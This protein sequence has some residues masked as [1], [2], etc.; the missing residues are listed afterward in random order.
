MPPA[1]PAPAVS[2]GTLH[3]N[4]DG[5][6]TGTAAALRVT[7]PDGQ[8][9]TVTGTATLAQRPPGTYVV[10]ATDVAA[11]DAVYH[12]SVEGSPARVDAGQTATVQVHYAPVALGITTF[13]ADHL[14]LPSTGGRVLLSWTAP[15]A[16]DFTLE[17]TP[18]GGVSGLPAPHTTERTAT[19][20]VPANPG[21][22]SLA[23]VFRL[24]AH[25]AQDGAAV[26][27]DLTVTVAGRA[28]GT[29]D[30]GV[31]GLPPGAPAAVTV[32]DPAGE[33]RRV[34]GPTALGDLPPGTYAVTAGSVTAGGLNYDGAVTGSPAQVAAAQVTRVGVTYTA[35]PVQVTLSRAA[36]VVA[37]RS[38][39][40]FT[41]TVEG[42]ASDAVTWTA[43][44]GTLRASGSLATWTAP[45]VA[46]TYTL[47]ATSVADPAQ[48]ASVT[49]TVTPLA[50]EWT[51]VAGLSSLGFDQVLD[52]ATDAQNNVYLVGITTGRLEG[53]PQGELDAFIAKVDAQGALQW[54]RQQAVS[55]ASYDRLDS[56]AVDAAGNVYAVGQTSG[57]L[58]GA[59]QDA[60]G[61]A[62]AV[63]FNAAGTRQWV[64]Q[65]A[66][67]TESFDSGRAVALD[68][69]GNVVVAGISTGAL[70][71]AQGGDGA[72]FVA[73]LTAGGQ[74]L[75]AVHGLTSGTDDDVRGVAV[76]TAGNVL[77][78][79]HRFVDY[80]RYYDAF[81]VKLTPQGSMAWRREGTLSTVAS[82]RTTGVVTDAAGNAYVLGTTA[83]TLEEGV[84]T[85]GPAFLAKFDPA[86]TR[87]WVRQ[88][89]LS[90]NW[91][92]YA[93]D[94]ALD[95][96]GRLYVSIGSD[97]RA[98]GSTQVKLDQAGVVLWTQPQLPDI[99]GA[100]FQGIITV[101]RAGSVYVA[102]QTG[103]SETYGD[104]S[105]EN[106]FLTKYRQ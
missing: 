63:K 86:G 73:K 71:T 8:V 92:S 38:A 45:D 100:P 93:G 41:A 31:T 42:A 24:T 64:Q 91:S 61:D 21:T 67:S 60:W 33:A 23:I 47:S 101:D 17:A 15:G 55:T 95:Q 105:G 44:G 12:A 6:P 52:M 68:A 22:D 58:E 39:S 84:Q 66:I 106:T 9:S 28:T 65:Q 32:I 80:S 48:R 87:L 69:Q 72:V 43:S 57:V 36:T 3:L 51:R 99:A 76:D 53:T 70:G 78:T 37:R 34:T 96:Q 98:D 46:G 2:T 19:V 4:V 102:G 81:L 89:A 20:E 90:T 27:Q 1:T 18:A 56:V 40:T 83:G 62:Y 13:A 79:G 77:L 16:S 35:R 54:V 103:F 7:A 88:H 74:R 104:N 30:V 94:L 85:F 26:S 25:R 82:D 5:L 11:G 50:A 59:G 97:W 10:T 29:L 14:A 75:W 49:L